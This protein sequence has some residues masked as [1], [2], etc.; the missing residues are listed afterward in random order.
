MHLGGVADWID[1]NHPEHPLYLIH[2]REDGQEKAYREARI[3]RQITYADTSIKTPALL[4]PLRALKTNRVSLPWHPT[5][6]IFIAGSHFLPDVWPVTGQGKKAPGAVRVVYIHHIVQD[7][8]RPNN[9]NTRLANVQEKFCL[10][11][12][13]HHFDKIIT[14]NQDVVDSLRSR[15]FTQPILLSSNFVNNHRATLHPYNAK[16][17]TLAFCGRLVAQ[18][19]I[20]D[21][22]YICEQL[23]PL[24]PGFK[25]VM[26]GVGP[27]AGRLKQ[28]IMAKNLAVELTGF[29]SEDH[30]FEL[31][32]RAK[33]FV[34]PSAEEGWG[35][36]IAESLSVGTPVLAYDLP[37]YHEPFGSDIQTVPLGNRKLLSQ[38]AK[39]L[40]SGYQQ[41]HANYGI[42]QKALLK[43]AALFSQDS[44]AGDE[45]DFMMG[46]QHGTS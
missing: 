13:R 21:F 22:V 7:M 25:A 18:K 15:G 6:N 2:A 32:A 41:D 28:T 19:G 37:V 11:L 20:H 1:T 16:D 10:N 12:I 39:E 23:Q 26:I 30:K 29:V 9:F 36:V 44:V 33:L 35:I 43:R 31:L 8:Q 17:I 38:K 45:F 14:V 27:E 5:S 40:L 34:L 42:L 24:I 4:Y 3:L 46:D